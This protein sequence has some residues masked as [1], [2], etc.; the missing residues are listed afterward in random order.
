MSKGTITA[1]APCVAFI[2]LWNKA[3]LKCKF[4]V[5]VILRYQ[6]K[7]LKAH[8]GKCPWVHVSGSE[9]VVIAE[10]EVSAVGTAGEAEP[11]HC[12][13]P[14]SAAAETVSAVSHTMQVLQLF[15]VF[16]WCVFV[17]SQLQ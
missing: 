11:P 13:P 14:K 1:A 6:R 3:C 5:F 4:Q 15:R 9:D 8:S 10:A 17:H 7:D 2:K 16:G 12:S